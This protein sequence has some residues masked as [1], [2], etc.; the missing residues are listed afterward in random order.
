MGLPLGQNG[1][2][3]FDIGMGALNAESCDVVGMFIFDQIQSMVKG[4]DHRI[5]RKNDTLDD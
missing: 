1:D 3:K 5:Y 4:S 2:H